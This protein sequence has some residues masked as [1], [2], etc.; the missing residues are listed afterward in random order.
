MRNGPSTKATLNL[1]LQ[2]DVRVW[3][4]KDGW[5]GPFKLLATDGETCTIDMPH[6][7][8]NF[9][10]TVVKPYYILPLPEASQEEEEIEEP[11]DDDRDESIDA[12]EQSVMK[13]FM[14]VIH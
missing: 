4:E 3:R 7:P 6:G 9:R 2:S 11:P 5:T 12:E 8:T 13:Y 14:V 1:P 10:S